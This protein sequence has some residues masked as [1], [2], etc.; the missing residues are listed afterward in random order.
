MAGVVGSH[1]ERM[2]PGLH[3]WVWVGESLW[4]WVHRWFAQQAGTMCARLVAQQASRDAVGG[5]Q[6]GC[7]GRLCASAV[8]RVPASRP[9]GCSRSQA[10]PVSAYG[11]TW[12]ACHVCQHFDLERQLLGPLLRIRQGHLRRGRM[13]KGWTRLQRA[14]LWLLRAECAKA[15]RASQYKR[16]PLAPT[17][18]AGGLS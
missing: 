14:R 6:A 12:A 15:Q 4:V 3:G 8:S 2:C 18:C 16:C 10:P 5:L 13:H 7:H 1:G 11:H 17:A 9:Y